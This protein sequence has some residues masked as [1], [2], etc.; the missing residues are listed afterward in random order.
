MQE[1]DSHIS[2]FG[3][4]L[5]S[6]IN[7][8]PTCAMLVKH[9]W[10]NHRALKKNLPETTYVISERYEEGTPFQIISAFFNLLHSLYENIYSISKKDGGI[11]F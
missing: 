9:H 8:K 3:Y 7:V 11:D 2:D 4:Y 1:G 10:G 6:W 5:Q